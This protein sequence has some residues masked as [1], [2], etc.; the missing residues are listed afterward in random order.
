MTWRM[1]GGRDHEQPGVVVQAG[2]VVVQPLPV[3]SVISATAAGQQ[4]R[5]GRRLGRRTAASPPGWSAAGAVL[6]GRAR[7]Q[8]P[9]GCAAAS[10]SPSSSASSTGVEDR[11]AGSPWRRFASVGRL[12]PAVVGPARCCSGSG[13]RGPVLAAAARVRAATR[14]SR[15]PTADRPAAPLRGRRGPGRPG[16]AGRRRPGDLV[17]GGASLPRPAQ[18]LRRGPRPGRRTA[19]RR[20][21]GA[22]RAR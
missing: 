5:R 12:P 9:A 15:W 14:R 8:R 7:Q 1:V 3:A 16:P 18:R 17:L 22:S 6:T 21:A 4:I 13:G 19:R 20:C 2:L 10:R 11:P